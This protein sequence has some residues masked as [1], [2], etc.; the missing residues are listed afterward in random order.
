[1]GRCLEDKCWIPPNF[2]LSSLEVYFTIIIYN[3]HPMII[4]PGPDIWI[5]FPVICAELRYYFT[6]SQSLV[7]PSRGFRRARRP[8]NRLSLKFSLKF[9]TLLDYLGLF[10]LF[11]QSYVLTSHRLEVSVLPGILSTITALEILLGD[12]L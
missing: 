11:G 3:A 1:M 8:R 12:E 5:E 9:V 10:L 7:C 4:S 6:S 2:L